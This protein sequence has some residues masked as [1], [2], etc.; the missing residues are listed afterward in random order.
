MRFVSIMLIGAVL[1]L[2]LA[3]AGEGQ[4]FERSREGGKGGNRGGADRPSFGMPGGGG[5]GRGM[6][7]GAG[8][9]DSGRP[10]FRMGDPSAMFDMMA[11]GKDVVSR[12]DVAPPM[13]PMFDR[14][15]E[16]MGI[17]NGQMTRQQF[18]SYMEQRMSG[19]GGPRPGGQPGGGPPGAP[20]G[21]GAPDPSSWADGSFRRLDQNGDGLLNYDEMPEAL[22]IEREK[23][24][25]NRD[26]FI[27]LTEYKAYFSARIQQMQQE[28][29]MGMGMPGFGSGQGQDEEEEKKPVVYRAGKLP[30]E[31]PSW[32]AE[33]DEDEDAQIGLYEWRR[34]GRALVEFAKIDRNGDGFLTVDEVLRYTAQNSEGN[35]ENGSPGMGGRPSFFAGQF[36]SPGSGGETPGRFSGMPGGGWGSWPGMTPG[37]GSW[38]GMNR[39]NGAMPG[40]G[41]DRGKGGRNGG[42]PW[43][44]SDRPKGEGKSK[45]G[46]RSPG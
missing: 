29:G 30:R 41:G 28:R 43:G 2:V 26:G 13:Q 23:W 46:R 1:L 17:T 9:A 19:G 18:S 8:G 16:R 36:P 7:G 31:L 10:S 45:D 42:G 3:P 22:R 32:F 15:A 20:G 37:G 35:G 11:Q 5:P 27:D 4:Q 39:G 34:G 40:M 38:P 24:D 6:F 21:G 12:N 25:A 44:K 14:M 33:L